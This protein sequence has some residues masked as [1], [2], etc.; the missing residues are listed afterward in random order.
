DA[1]RLCPH[2]GVCGGCLIQHMPYEQQ[3]A[4]KAKQ[5][6]TLF[7]DVYRGQIDIVPSPA[8]Y[9]YRNKIDPA[10]S[11]EWFDAPPPP[12]TVRKAVLGFKARGN[13]F[14]TVYIEDCLIGPEGLLELF[15]SVREWVNDQQLAPYDSRRNIGFLRNLLIRKACRT[16]D[17]MVMLITTPG[18]ID[19]ES[20]VSTVHAAW[21]NASV[22]WGTFSGR[23]EVAAADHVEILAGIGEID[24]H[25]VIPDHLERTWWPTP[26]DALNDMAQIPSLE[27]HRK[28]LAFRISP[29]A[30][31]QTNTLATERL[32]ARI[33]AWVDSIRPPVLYDLYGGMG[34]IALCVSDLVPQIHSVEEV[35]AAV[36]DGKRNAARQ[37]V[38]HIY[39]HQSRVRPWL[40]EQ[41]RSG[42]IPPD[43]AVIVDPP[44]AGLSPR[45]VERLITLAPR[46]MLYVSCNPSVLARE[47]PAFLES[48][49]LVSLEAVDLFP[50]TPH[51]ETIAT[52]ERRET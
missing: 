40:K 26:K 6:A 13:W 24:E 27:G 33:R 42:G 45:V 44:R 21:P 30:F 11:P 10:F 50:H 39:F 5:L 49:H 7:S 18:A 20:F 23:G 48:Y 15:R 12:G 43:S 2:F 29:M 1:I 31:F 16:E 22:L 41:I 8:I 4:E 14:R 32:Y 36:E 37:G 19:R 17:R 25:L 9:H 52:L 47:L 35:A 34:T 3:L 28:K 51:V 46:N 38:S